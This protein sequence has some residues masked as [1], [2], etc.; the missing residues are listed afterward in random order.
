[1]KTILQAMTEKQVP[2]NSNFFSLAG[3]L[4][5]LIHKGGINNNRELFSNL[6]EILKNTTRKYIRREYNNNLNWENA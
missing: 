6:K 2:R 4:H 5:T 1:M 3:R